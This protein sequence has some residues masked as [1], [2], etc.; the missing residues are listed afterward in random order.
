MEDNYKT[1]IEAYRLFIKAMN[2][3]ELKKDVDV[4]MYDHSVEF[5]FEKLYIYLDRVEKN[6]IEEDPQYISVGYA[7]IFICAYDENME[8]SEIFELYPKLLNHVDDILRADLPLYQIVDLS[9]YFSDIEDYTNYFKCVNE[10]SNYELQ[11]MM[12][13][14]MLVAALNNIDICR[15]G[16]AKCYM[17]GLGTE[18]DYVKAF[19]LL[20]NIGTDHLVLKHYGNPITDEFDVLYKYMQKDFRDGKNYPGLGFCLGLMSIEGI[21]NHTLVSD[22]EGFMEWEEYHHPEFY[23]NHANLLNYVDNLDHV[24]YSILYNTFI[25][26]I[27]KDIKINDYVEYKKYNNRSVIW[28]VLDV[29]DDKA[30]LISIDVLESP[31]IAAEHSG[32]DDGYNSFVSEM[33]EFYENDINDGNAFI[34]TKDEVEKYMKDPESRKCGVRYQ[35]SI[36][37]YDNSGCTSAWFTSTKYDDND[38]YYFVDEEGEIDNDNIVRN[39]I[40]IRPAIWIKLGD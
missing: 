19:M 38:N 27:P 40:G 6:E 4:F 21:G 30:L 3:N 37:G 24:D 18:K 2:I 9:Y 36:N 32:S 33:F 10:G 8:F 34:L 13:G 25:P 16:L 7:N 29:K 11:G 20:Y 1:E 22:Y 31:E 35:A 15:L 26:P 17:D 23:N 14:P 28:K 39:Y 12:G 5:D